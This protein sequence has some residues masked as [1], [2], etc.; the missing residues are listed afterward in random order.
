MQPPVKREFLLV[1]HNAPEQQHHNADIIM[2]LPTNSVESSSEVVVPEPELTAE[3]KEIIA[4][5]DKELDVLRHDQKLKN[6]GGRPDVVTSVVVLKLVSAFQSGMDTTTACQYSGI[7]RATFYKHM[8]EDQEFSDIIKDAK[9]YL[10]LTSGDRLKTII[11]KGDER[12]AGPLAFKYLERRIPELYGD[13]KIEKHQN[14][15]IVI[16]HESIRELFKQQSGIATSNPSE[17]LKS[18]EVQ[19]EGEL[20]L[21]AEEASLA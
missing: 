5:A 11:E 17:L 1:H 21:R 2:Q 6:P 3:Q 4:T 9:D 10:K 7:S 12:V 14:N 15:F 8:K 18:V 13:A 16:T 19:P 20:D